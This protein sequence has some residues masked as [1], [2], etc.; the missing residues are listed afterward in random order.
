[1]N[2]DHVYLINENSRWLCI[3]TTDSKL[4]HIALATMPIS[5]DDLE[6]FDKR[7][8]Y[9]YSSKY[10]HKL[11]GRENLLSFGALPSEL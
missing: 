6:Y 3:P 5:I 8:Y 2:T 4:H 10:T 11:F 9:C 7:N 1:M